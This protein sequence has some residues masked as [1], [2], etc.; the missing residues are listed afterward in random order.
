MTPSRAIAAVLTAGLVAPRAVLTL[1]MKAFTL[2]LDTPG[3]DRGRTQA[4]VRGRDSRRSQRE[5]TGGQEEKTGGQEETTAELHLPS[6][7]K[8]LHGIGQPGQRLRLVL[9]VLLSEGQRH[10]LSRRTPW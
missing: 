9:G 6:K 4:S 1:V 5:K 3:R 8:L 2:T 10:H 7:A